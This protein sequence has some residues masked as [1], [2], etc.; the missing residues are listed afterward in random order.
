[1]WEG[2]ADL[3]LGPLEDAAVVAT[4]RD[5]LVVAREEADVGDVR[6]VA[7]ERARVLARWVRR[8]APPR[9]VRTLL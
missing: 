6:R 1:M 5:D 3:A 8:P 4:G 2:R 9:H 7:R